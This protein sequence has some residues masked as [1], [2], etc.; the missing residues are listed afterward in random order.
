VLA[1]AEA[2]EPM[3]PAERDALLAEAADWPTI[4]PLEMHAR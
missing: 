3:T 2:Y 4:F 1:A